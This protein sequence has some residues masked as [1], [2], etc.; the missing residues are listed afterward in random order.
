MSPRTIPI[1]VPVPDELLAA[2]INVV[3]GYLDEAN[4]LL[5]AARL[6]V[7]EES[8]TRLTR[9]RAALDRLDGIRED[10]ARL[11]TEYRYL[12]A[13]ARDAYDETIATHAERN[14]DGLAARG[15]SYEE[16]NLRYKYTDR[17]AFRRVQA[18]ARTLRYLED[19]QASIR[20]SIFAADR[21]RMEALTLFRAG[22]SITADEYAHSS[23]EA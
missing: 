2:L 18:L 19:A 17:P 15:L 5:E 9:T 7:V 23:T 14:A 10:L 1:S 11:V 3:D 22:R 21:H 20:D 16:R 13:D 4:L 6:A 12:H 8:F